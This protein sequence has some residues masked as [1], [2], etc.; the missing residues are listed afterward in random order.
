MILSQ[1]KKGLSFPVDLST[2]TSTLP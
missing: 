2:E 1:H